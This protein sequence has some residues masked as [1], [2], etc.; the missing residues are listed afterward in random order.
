MRALTPQWA[1][2][3]RPS[4]STGS[5]SGSR[6]REEAPYREVGGGNPCEACK[7]TGVCQRC[8]G[9]SWFTLRSG[10]KVRCK[11]CEPRGP[12]ASESDRGKCWPCHGRGTERPT[13]HRRDS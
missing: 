8:E 1:R 13:R 6:R 12:K 10:T 5:G 2:Y 4:Y 7:G 3:Q 11:A 9:T